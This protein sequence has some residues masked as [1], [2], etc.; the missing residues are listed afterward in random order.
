M[1]LKGVLIGLLMFPVVVTWMFGQAVVKGMQSASWP[2]IEAKVLDSKI[3]QGS[4]RRG[5]YAH[6]TYTYAIAGRN[7]SGS[8]TTFTL[9]AYSVDAIAGSAPKGAT[10]KV[11]VNP[12]NAAEAVLVPGFS[13]LDLGMIVIAWVVAVAGAVV[14][15]KYAPREK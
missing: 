2:L 12:S 5:A 15:W 9:L 1:K 4:S 3:V 8:Q 14:L 11:A 10:V 7:Y 13:W 6:V